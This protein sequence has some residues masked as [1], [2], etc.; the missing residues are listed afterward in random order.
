MDVQKLNA[1]VELLKRDMGDSLLATNIFGS[2]DG[3]AIAGYNTQEKANA[4]FAQL[5]EYLT[6]ALQGSGFPG[7]GKYY[8]MDLTDAKMAILIP[9]A[10]YQWGMLV[11]TNKAKLG[12]LLNVVMPKI[13]DAFE[14]AIT[15]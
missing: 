5:T 1:A 15:G 9:L 7:L 14:E 3:Q 12:L 6:K 4:L 11:D 10:D 2:A 13:I 8:M